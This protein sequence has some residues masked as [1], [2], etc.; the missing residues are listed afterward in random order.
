MARHRVVTVYLISFSKTFHGEQRFSCF[1]PKQWRHAKVIPLPKPGKDHSNPSN[2]RPISLLSSIS[3]IFERIIRKC[4]NT[5]I[6]SNNALPNNQFGFRAA[7]STSH[8]L[9]RSVRHVKNRRET[10]RKPFYPYKMSERGL[11]KAGGLLDF[12][13][14]Y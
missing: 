14:L 5:F 11:L 9:N 10:W 13:L 3:K 8:Q 12:F 7:H 6:A 1:F 4:L 2:Y